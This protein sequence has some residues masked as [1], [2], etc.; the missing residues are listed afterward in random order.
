MVYVPSFR[1][2]LVSVSKLDSCGYTFNIDNGKL[3]LYSGSLM[4]GSA[5]LYDGLYKFD[6][7]ISSS[8]Y[9]NSSFVINYVVTNPKRARLD[10]NSSMLWHKRLGHISKQRIERLIKDGT[11]PQLDFSDFGICIDCIKGKHTRAK[12]KGATRKDEALELIHTDICGPFTPTTMGGYRYF[13]TFIDDFSRFGFIYLIQEKS[14]SLDAFKVFKAEVEL[15]REKKIKSVRSD[16]GGEFYGRYDE[17]GRN[18]GPFARFLQ[19]C[20]IDAQYT[21]PGSPEQNGVAER[22]NRTLMDMV[23]SMISNSTLPDFLWG[24]ALKTAVYI[25]NKVP[26]KSVP[27][28]PYELWTGKKSN[29]SHFHIW[30]CAAEV[31]PYNP[32]MR[33]LDP[34][35]ISGHFIGY[36]ERSRGYRFYCPTHS[37]RVVESN[38][39]VFF[40]DDLDFQSAQPRNFVFEEEHV[41]VPMPVTLPSTVLQP[42]IEQENVPT[43]EP[44]QPIVVEPAPP[45]VDEIQDHI[46]AD[47]P[48]RKSERTRRPAISDD[49]VVYLQEHEFDITLDSD[50]ISFDQASNDPNSSMW[51]FA[52]QDELNSM[53]VNDV[54]N[55]VELPKGCRPIG[56][57]W[58]FKTKRNSKG[59]IERYKAR[60]VAKGFSQREGID[61]KETFSPVSTKD[62]FR[63]IM[64][65]VAHFDLEL[66]QM[67]VK[68]AF[69]N[70]DLEEDVYM[71]QPLG[72]RQADTE[73]LV[74]KLKKSIYGLKQTSRQ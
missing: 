64:A 6:L 26:S 48:L 8:K 46:V 62:S 73:H 15:K 39:A 12:K 19:E 55:L 17:T 34:R 40:E 41:L 4:V 56:C 31:R 65:L 70:G 53:S 18:P 54:W 13:I 51:M 7:D 20:G 69:L 52:M 57:K 59:E 49:Y 68:T 43:H 29:L 44:V 35:T 1:R 22:R 27:R 42:H 16:Q 45:V 3:T 74:C 67:D 36:S 38:R 5:L 32:Q 61:Y 2:K 33:K 47:V 14:E 63:I 10:E 25:L 37:T 71:Q 23:R 66:H 21:M 28:T 24:D 72:F 30:G 11:L 9:A 60:L 50:P 58:I